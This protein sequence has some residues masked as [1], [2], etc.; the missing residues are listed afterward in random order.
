M[1]IHVQ[2]L[3]RRTGIRI[4][5]NVHVPSISICKHAHKCT[6]THILSFRIVKEG[7]QAADANATKKHIEEI[8][9]CG[10][11]LLEAGKKADQVFNVPPTSTSHTVCDATEDILTMT[12]DLLVR[13]AVEDTDQLGSP[14]IDPTTRGMED[15]AAKGW[16]ESMLQSE[17]TFGEEERDL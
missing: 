4:S 14:F 10:M 2:E 13:A 15:K 9:L 1:Y 6:C 17:G 5:V 8:S 12:R 16:I 3:Y 11:F 7:V